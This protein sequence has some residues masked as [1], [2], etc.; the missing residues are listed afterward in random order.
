[1]VW[2]AGAGVGLTW[3]SAFGVEIN[4]LGSGNAVLSS[5]VV[6]NGTAL[7]KFCD[8]SFV[9]G[10]TVTTAAP[11]NLA[12]YVYPLNEDAA[13]YGDGRFGTAAAGPPAGNYEGGSIGFAAAASTTIAGVITGIVIPPGSF[14]FLLMNN[15]GVALAASNVCK[16]RTYN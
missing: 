14:S 3:S 7:D 15:A 1:M 4:S 2:I 5:I 16:Y 8:I 13:T 10:A 12:F 6:A 9:A 11:N